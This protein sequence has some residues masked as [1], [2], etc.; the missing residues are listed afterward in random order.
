MGQKDLIKLAVAVV[1]LLIGVGLIVVRGGGDSRTSG[2]PAPESL[3]YLD[4]QS[5]KLFEGPTD[6]VASI[7]A[8]SGGDGVRAF[9]YTCGECTEAELVVGYVQQLN[10]KAIKASRDLEGLEE[11]RRQALYGVIQQG[12]FVARKPGAG[13]DPQWMSSGTPGGAEVMQ[14]F[15]TICGENKLALICTPDKVK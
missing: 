3:Y 7:P 2:G 11:E 15:R 8:P 14:S 9:V 6:A 12:T 4:L 13:V 5:G 1:L 10:D